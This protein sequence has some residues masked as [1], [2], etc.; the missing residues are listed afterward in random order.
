MHSAIQPPSARRSLDLAGLDVLRGLLALYVLIGHA[1][2]ILWS[3]RTAWASQPYQAWEWPIAHGSAVFHYGHEAV[4]LFF[5]LS[6]FFIHLRAAQDLGVARRYALDNL[7]YLK[8][9]A[10]RL[11]PPYLLALSVTVV[12]DLIGRALSPELFFGKT[13]DPTLD[14]YFLRCGFTAK[15]IVAAALLLPSSL[16]E[17]F[18][19]NGALWSL[20]FEVLFYCIYPLWLAIRQWNVVI[21]FLVVPVFCLGVSLISTSLG[22]GGAVLSHYP[23]WLAGAGL[24][25]LLV[26][27]KVKS[28]TLLIMS[29]SFICS[30]GAYL[31][32]KN[33]TVRLVFGLCFAGSGVAAFAMLDERLLSSRML[34]F[35]RFL[36]IR[37]YT[38]YIVH[39]PFL[40]LLSG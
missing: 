8:R 31:A 28:G 15:S 23:I 25:E 21:A 3:G 40:A 38:I 13:G 2:W 35:W 6:G 4:L 20:A 7:E 9:R 39:F 14:A 19:S 32:C 11:V 18:G 30:F 12:L 37:S 29:I 22:F 16:Y 24:A 36:G 33:E 5:A 34:K 1:R 10:H 26:R 27:Y 17:V